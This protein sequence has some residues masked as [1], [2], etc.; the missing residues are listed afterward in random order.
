ITHQLTFYIFLLS[1]LSALLITSVQWYIYYENEIN[2]LVS[3]AINLVSFLFF[4][5]LIG[6]IFHSRLVRHLKKIADYTE[7]IDS[8]NLET[9]LTLDR[10]TRSIDQLDELEH[11]VNSVN[12][13]RQSYKNI[14]TSKQDADNLLNTTLIGLGLWRFDGTFIQVNPAYAQMIGRSVTE[15][16]KLNYWDDIVEEKEVTDE[17]ARLKIL[18][19]A[20]QYGPVEKE[21]RHK[22]GYSV[23]VRLSALILEK[24]GEYYAWS[25]IENLS[26]QKWKNA[27]LQHAKQK[28]EEANLAKSQSLAN[29]SHELRTPMNTIVGYTEMLEEEVRES[30]QSAFLLPDVKNIHTAAKHLLG[31]IDGILDISKIESGKMQLYAERFDLNKMIQNTITTLQPLMENRANALHILSDEYLG[32][33][34]T[35]M[36]KVRQILFNLLSNASK[37]TEQGTITLEIRRQSD[38]S[39]DWIIFCVSDEGIGMTNEQQANL[40]QIFKEDSSTTHQYGGTDLGLTI[41]KHFASMLGGTIT[42]KSEFGKGS[43]FTVRIPTVLKIDVPPGIAEI[44]EMVRIPEASVGGVLLVIDDDETVRELLEIYLGKVGYQVV[45]ASSGKEGL[46]LAKNLRP[47]AITLDVMMPG[48]DGWEVLSKLK[49]DPELSH[50]P[51]IMLTM[52]EDKEIGYSLGAA[53]YLTKPISRTQLI[54]VLRKYRSDKAACVVMVVEDDAVTREMMVRILNKVGWQVIEA[55]N[56]EIALKRLDEHHPDL[57]LLDLMMPEMDGFEFIIHLRQ[58]HTCSSTPVVVLTAKDITIKDRLWLN[59]RVDTVFQKGAY[60]RDELLTELR[61]LLVTAVNPS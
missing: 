36:P 26:E 39:G 61:Q 38:Q 57:I 24:Q 5:L 53:E 15:I 14:L 44:S 20:E 35:D 47:D 50:I 29:M 40:F 60:S 6:W 8:E 58:H 1:I 31:L 2:P 45:L 56:G 48:M 43:H 7:H 16:L 4:T 34:H 3:L 13:M 32:E 37:F 27:E 42:V 25:H 54:K 12:K 55:E 11:L 28:A 23:P 19:Q 33:L 17:K 51:V 41:T 21:Y 46:K 10:A 18:K 9:I 30:K 59:N 22:D 49:A 52:T